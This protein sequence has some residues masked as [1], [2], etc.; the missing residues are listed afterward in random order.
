MVSTPAQRISEL[1]VDVPEALDEL[2]ANMLALEWQDR[3]GTDQVGAR[4]LELCEDPHLPRIAAAIDRQLDSAHSSASRLVTTM[5]AIAV[6][7]GAAR[8]RELAR[9][10]EIGAEAVRLGKDSIVAYLGARQALGGEALRAIEIGKYLTELGAQ[11]GVATGRALVDLARPVGEVVDK[12]SAL[13]REA[14]TGQ[15]LADETSAELARSRFDFMSGPSSAWVVGGS[16][17]ERRQ[18]TDQTPFVGRGTEIEALFTAY[19]RSVEA[20]QPV[21]VSVSGPP[22]IGKSRLAREFLN[23]VDDHPTAPTRDRAFRGHASFRFFLSS[24]RLAGTRGAGA[25][26]SLRTRSSVGYRSRHAHRLASFAQRRPL[27]RGCTCHRT[28]W[29]GSR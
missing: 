23:R 20:D 25:L 3:P 4:L 13:A 11:V 1:V 15:M 22:G 8:D 7:T 24:N 21:V 16:V 2:L 6:G 28:T 12:A 14:K 27:R 29:S 26:R 5:V 9:M 17:P 18:S 19:E 10:R